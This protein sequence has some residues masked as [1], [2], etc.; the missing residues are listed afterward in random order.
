MTKTKTSTT[1]PKPFYIA[2]KDEIKSDAPVVG[3]EFVTED[4]DWQGQTVEVQSDTKLEADKGT[5]EAVIIRTFEFALN[6]EVFRQ[7]EQRTGS[8]PT[9]QQI[10]IE[11][12]KGVESF[13]WQDGL[14]PAYDIEPR[15]IFAKGTNKYL[16][17]V[18]ARPQKGQMIVDTPKTLS[19]LA[20][21]PRDSKN[22]VHGVV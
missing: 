22:K 14:S 19:E 10:F 18:G 17:M 7:H 6:P 5:G 21:D 16:I 13:L 11:H 12:Q 4:G 15:V 3:G 1:T 2:G 8:Q 9:P 20:N